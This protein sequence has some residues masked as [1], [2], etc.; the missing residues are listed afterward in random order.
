VR[1]PYFICKIKAWKIKIVNEYDR[2]GFVGG[3]NGEHEWLE[4]KSGP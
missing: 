1:K 4:K 3:I 2:G